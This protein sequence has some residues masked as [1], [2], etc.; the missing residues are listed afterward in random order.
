MPERADGAGDAGQEF[1]WPALMRLGLRRLHLS[2]EVFW[3]LT[4][5]ELI[6]IAGL[7]PGGG[8]MA[9]GDLS[10]LLRRYPDTTHSE[11]E[12]HG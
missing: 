2:P 1:D 4:P 10:A 5:A 12:H 9:R 7:K 8:A 3:A 11:G 6:C